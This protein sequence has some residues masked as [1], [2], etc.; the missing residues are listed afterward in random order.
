MLLIFRLAIM[1]LLLLPKEPA[2]AQTRLTP[3]AFLDQASGRTL[4]FTA[5][6]TGAVVGVEQF[7]NRKQSVWA[8]GNGRCTYGEIEVR[9]HLICFIYEDMP[10]PLNCWATFQDKGDLLVIST[11][12]RQVQR[13]TQ[14]TDRPVIC[15]DEALS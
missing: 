6:G 11:R 8:N 12:S 14:I 7:L 9:G 2:H 5:H 1:A 13:V 10:D 4:T 3:E 15:E